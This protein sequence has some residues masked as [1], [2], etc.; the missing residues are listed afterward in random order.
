VHIVCNV[1]ARPIYDK[2]SACRLPAK[3]NLICEICY[4]KIKKTTMYYF[5]SQSFYE[6]VKLT[7]HKKQ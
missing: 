5:I 7:W 1:C 6:E 2:I 3:R 4:G